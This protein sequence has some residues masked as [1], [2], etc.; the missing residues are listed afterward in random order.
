MKAPLVLYDGHCALCNGFI[1]FLLRF[2]KQKKF[3][4]ASLQSKVSTF[5][6]NKYNWDNSVDTVILI[7]DDSVYMYEEAAFKVLQLL[8]FPWSL[9][10]LF[11]IIPSYISRAIYKGIARKRYNWFGKYENCPI[12]KAENRKQF[13]SDPNELD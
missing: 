9:F 3:R 12:P 10:L 5:Y 4:F 6:K 2:D 13:I 7:A 8:E 1:G 11:K